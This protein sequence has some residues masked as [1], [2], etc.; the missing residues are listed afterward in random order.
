MAEGIN[1]LV[2]LGRIFSVLYGSIRPDP[3]PLS[4]LADLGVI[5]RALERD[6]Q[7][8]FKTVLLRLQN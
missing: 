6:V 5:R 1:V 8:D 3:K 7:C 2:F 4:M